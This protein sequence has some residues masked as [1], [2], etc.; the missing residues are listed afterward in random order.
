MNTELT[1]RRARFF[2]QERHE[3]RV[4]EPERGPP[5][6]THLDHFAKSLDERRQKIHGE[7]REIPDPSVRRARRAARRFGDVHPA[8]EPMPAE[9]KGLEYAQLRFS[10]QELR[11]R[12]GEVGQIRPRMTDVT[13]ARI[14]RPA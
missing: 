12:L 11:N 9:V 5:Q 14:E 4:V 10:I 13:L 7:P 3:L 2:A 1:Q 8:L 6:V